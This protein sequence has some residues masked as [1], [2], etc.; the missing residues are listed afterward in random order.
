MATDAWVEYINQNKNY[1]LIFDRQVENL[2]V[3]NQ[4]AREQ[5][6]TQGVVGVITDAIS[7]LGFGSMLGSGIGGYFGKSG[8]G[9]GAGI[10]AAVG[11]IAMGA[12]SAVG[13]A[14]DK[15]YLKRSQTEAVS[16]MK[17]QHA[18]QIGSIQAQPY[19]LTKVS[20]FNIN[21]KI[22]PFLEIYE[23]T[24]EEVQ[25]FT[26]QLTYSGMTVNAMGTIE[27]YQQSTPS[28]IRGKIIR[29]EIDD[30]FTIADMIANEIA[31][32]VYI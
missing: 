26:Q 14:F 25:A 7:G 23:A 32:G 6:N 8:T 28:F 2:E 19:S 30:N 27:Q 21:N 13:F 11:G 15:E 18:L 31:K 17:D 16:Y 3:N 9:I 29:L 12:A 22:F 20:A 5:Q 24:D 4:I 10:G 1:N